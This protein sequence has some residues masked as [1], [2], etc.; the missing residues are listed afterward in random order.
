MDEGGV[1][2]RLWLGLIALLFGSQAEKVPLAVIGGML[3]VIGLELIVARVP[4]ARLVLRTGAWAP[5]AAMAITFLSALFIPLRYTIF[6]GAG[7]SL[8]L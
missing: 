5:V 1:F 6:L 7:L 8:V 2:A 4:S 3:T